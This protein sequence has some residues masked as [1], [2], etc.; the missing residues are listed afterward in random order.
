MSSPS[1][2]PPP[3]TQASTR[4]RGL[5]WCPEQVLAQEKLGPWHRE[6]FPQSLSVPIASPP[7]T[8]P[9]FMINTDP[10]CPQQ[11]LGR[12]PGHSPGLV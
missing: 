5:W 8:H 7:Q 10:P 12:A 6:V 2:G 3:P 1:A 9:P 11:G 4:G